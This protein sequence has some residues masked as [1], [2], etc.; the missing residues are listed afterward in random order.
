V[1]KRRQSPAKISRP[2]FRGVLERQALFR[3]L[4]EG[5]RSPVFWIA[6]PAGSGKTTLVASYLSSRRLPAIWYDL[7]EGD[8]DP[9]TFFHYMGLAAEEAAPRRRKPLP[10]LTPEY[11]LGVPTFAR[12]FFEDLFSRLKSPFCLVLD[13]YQDVPDGSLLHDVL[14][15]GLREVPDGGSVLI[16]SR[17]APPGQYARLRANGALAML[18]SNQLPLSLSESMQL[19]R[20]K[21]R[22]ID[23]ETVRELH[24]RSGGWAA[25]L[26]L[27][28]EG[29]GG[30]EAN[31]GASGNISQEDLFNYFSSEILD[32]TSPETRDFLL[33]TSVFCSMTSAMARDLTGEAKAERILAQLCR[34]NLFTSR[35]PGAEPVYQYHDLFRDFLLA[36]ANERF[37]A[38]EMKE[39]RK[40]AGRIAEA[41]GFMEDAA[42][43]YCEAEDWGSLSALLRTS[44]WALLAQGRNQA[45]NGWLGCLP[46]QI[47]DSDPWLLYCSAASLSPYD[48]A[49]VRGLFEKALRL[50]RS[51]KEVAGAFLAWSGLIE[52]FIFGMDFSEDVLD[53]AS[54]LDPLLRELGDPPDVTIEARMASCMFWA[55]MASQPW[56]RRT[57]YWEKRALELA[58][59]CGDITIKAQTLANHIYHLIQRGDLAQAGIR[60]GHFREVVGS[61]ETPSLASMFMSYVES[62]YYNVI[63]DYDAALAAAE[64][65]L[66]FSERTGVH[67]MDPMLLG[68][69][70]LSLLNRGD[71][72]RAGAYLERMASLNDRMRRA[73]SFFY[74]YVLAH[75]LLLEGDAPKAVV[76]SEIAYRSIES[77]AGNLT[78]RYLARLL[79]AFAHQANGDHRKAS[80]CAR[81]AFEIARMNRSKIGIFYA[82]IARAHIEITCGN[83]DEGLRAL[84]KAMCVG[85]QHGYYSIHAWYPDVMAKLCAV[86]LDEGIETAYVRD[87]VVK[88]NLVPNPPPVGMEAWPWPVKIFTL[89][90]FSLLVNGRPVTAEDKTRKKPLEMLKALVAFDSDSVS[91]ARIAD[92][93]WPEADGDAAHNAFTTTLHRLRKI[94]GDPEA[95]ILKNQRLSLNF[96]RCWVDAR[97]MEYLLA[98]AETGWRSDGE[99]RRRAARAAER[100]VEL[101]RGTFLP[102][103]LEEPW[104][105]HR[106]ER[107]RSRFLRAVEKLGELLEA[108]GQWEQA[109]GH[110]RKALEVDPLFEALHRRLMRGYLRQGRTVEALAAFDRCR[111]V[112]R[113]ALGVDPSSKTRKLYEEIRGQSFPSR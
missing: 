25:G 113:S 71:I 48:P 68:N 33:E 26:V 84:R 58:D 18:D 22:D 21:R 103:E 29:L 64:G 82:H 101:Y 39:L 24:R 36:V 77:L 52:T 69:A 1:G 87:L 62:A 59:S 63:G 35:H 92:V 102:Q 66:A 61:G 31:A 46:R 5:L 10:R 15:A 7:D 47:L 23:E 112:V 90:R 79:V 75:K 14:P 74:H 50:F 56:Q 3:E 97:A 76:N 65:W 49:G 55:L 98:E 85:R 40:R 67:I 70:A 43:L 16:L 38:G 28:L 78:Q 44:A 27:L 30:N 86:A 54:K 83:R 53:A 104:A 41:A 37:A 8:A 93:L 109:C 17:G 19:V 42:E 111:D 94:L 80:R 9:A 73:D 60:L 108:D 11:M 12:R 13:N 20:L 72:R 100:A 4:D 34:D 99:E 110:Y 88:R 95:L 51:S 106:R 105:V 89:G 32:R 96:H 6:G 81:G 2:V 57:L 107:L 91:E 45:L